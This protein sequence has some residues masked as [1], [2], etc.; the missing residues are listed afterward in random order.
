[1]YYAEKYVVQNYLYTLKPQQSH[2]WIELCAHAC[3]CVHIHIPTY[4]HWSFVVGYMYKH[5]HNN[6]GFFAFVF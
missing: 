6:I 5:V 3:L 1:M 2:P 4:S